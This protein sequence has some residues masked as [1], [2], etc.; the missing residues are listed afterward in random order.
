MNI[1]TIKSFITVR[2]HLESELSQVKLER[3]QFRIDM[4]NLK[5]RL[6]IIECEIFEFD[7]HKATRNDE[8]LVDEYCELIGKI[9]VC[10]GAMRDLYQKEND[11]KRAL[12]NLTS[13]HS[14]LVTSPLRN[15]K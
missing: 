11:L 12:R 5:Q 13:E 9:E 14:A 2:R 6:V 8:E 7:D 3:E 4:K 1:Q 10:E 15:H